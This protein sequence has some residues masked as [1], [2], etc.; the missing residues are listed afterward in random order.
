MRNNLRKD[1]DT[2]METAGEVWVQKG[3][4]LGLSQ[5]TVALEALSCQ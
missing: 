1:Q 4:M 2:Q 5:A 3:V